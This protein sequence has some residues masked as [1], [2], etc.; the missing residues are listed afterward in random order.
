[1]QN[2]RMNDDICLTY[3]GIM[4]KEFEYKTR[5]KMLGLKWLIMY[6]IQSLPCCLEIFAQKRT[7]K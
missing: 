6:R 4:S 7:L 3:S 1:M 5:L 2:L